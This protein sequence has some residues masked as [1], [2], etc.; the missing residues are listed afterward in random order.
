MLILKY[1]PQFPRLF[2]RHPFAVASFSHARSNRPAR[3]M[4]A[5]SIFS[6]SF[7]IPIRKMPSFDVAPF[8]VFRKY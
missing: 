8:S 2:V 5:G 4:S 6:G 3:F 1:K 7:V